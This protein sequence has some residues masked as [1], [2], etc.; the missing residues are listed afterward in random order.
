MNVRRITFTQLSLYAIALVFVLLRQH[1]PVAGVPGAL[2]F[3]LL[4]GAVRVYPRFWN[5]WIQTTYPRPLLAVEVVNG[6]LGTLVIVATLELFGRR[7]ARRIQEQDADD[8]GHR[9]RRD[10]PR[11]VSRLQ[12]CPIVPG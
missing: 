8:R 3:G 10:H 2:A 12:V 1:F 9:V 11:T 6:T 5:M 4:V 7:S